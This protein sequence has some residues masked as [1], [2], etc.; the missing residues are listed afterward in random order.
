MRKPDLVI[1]PPDNPQTLRWIIF[2]WRGWQLALHKWLR[3]DE[4]RAPHDHKGH[5]ISFILSR[6][7]YSELVREYA[8]TWLPS[9]WQKDGTGAIYRDLWWDRSA[10]TPHFR[11]AETPHR[12]ALYDERPVWSLWFRYPPYRR[13]G[14]WCPKGWVDADDFLSSKDYYGEG[15]S[16][17]GRGCG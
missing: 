5:N 2:S 7:G 12:I 4:D 8:G 10:W 6:Q 17:T 11:H 3:S 13:W 1:G 14:F 15:S 16:T 9:V